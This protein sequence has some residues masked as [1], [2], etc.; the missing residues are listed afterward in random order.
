MALA[1]I[2]EG[3]NQSDIAKPSFGSETDF[4]KMSSLSYFTIV[5]YTQLA[6]SDQSLILLQA[7]F[8][9]THDAIVY[10]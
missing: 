8:F 5:N 1:E 3:R 10:S 6:F 4:L 2:I 7:R 9:E